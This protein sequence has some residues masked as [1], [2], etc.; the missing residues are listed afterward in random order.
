MTDHDRMNHLYEVVD[1]LIY[2]IITSAET[3]DVYPFELLRKKLA[4]GIIEPQDAQ[5]SEEAE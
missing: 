5:P 3:V 2:E 1:D 4:E